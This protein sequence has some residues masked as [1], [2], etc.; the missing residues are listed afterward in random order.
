MS[1]FMVFNRG[2]PADLMASS[3]RF[4]P[5]FPKTIS[6]ASRIASG[7]AIGIRLRAA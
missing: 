1:G 5:M 7:S 4:S 2:I 6:D 3:S